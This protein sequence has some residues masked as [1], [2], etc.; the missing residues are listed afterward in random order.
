MNPRPKLGP[1]VPRKDVYDWKQLFRSNV[2]K[3]HA[4]AKSSVPDAAKV[5]VAEM[6]TSKALGYTLAEAQKI[7][8]QQM[9]KEELQSSRRHSGMAEMAN[10]APE[11]Y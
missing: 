8:L 10:E 3:L 7:D 6:D 11:V 5:R 9:A 2:V 4:G 1:V